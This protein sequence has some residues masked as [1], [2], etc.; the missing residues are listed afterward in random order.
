MLSEALLLHTYLELISLGNRPFG[1]SNSFPSPADVPREEEGLGHWASPQWRCPQPCMPQG[2]TGARLSLGRRAQSGCR[3]PC[4]W[5]PGFL[6]S[7]VAH[8]VCDLSKPFSS[9]SHHFHD[10]SVASHPLGGLACLRSL[11]TCFPCHLGSW[12]DLR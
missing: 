10:V 11:A 5:L 1:I 2:G 8:V 6:N 12:V 4:V 3:T 7:P 9:C